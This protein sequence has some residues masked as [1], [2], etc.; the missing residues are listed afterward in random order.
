MYGMKTDAL[1]SDVS[2]DDCIYRYIQP[3]T[4][5]STAMR[6]DKQWGGL[7]CVIHPLCAQNC[8]GNV[9]TFA[10]SASDIP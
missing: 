6:V 4:M 3:A 7:G 10:S 5:L 2:Q 1:Y 8:A 9:D